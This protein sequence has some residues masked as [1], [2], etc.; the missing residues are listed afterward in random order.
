[1]RRIFLTAAILSVLT[2][3]TARA[4]LSIDVSSE[5]IRV[6]TGFNGSAITIFGVQEQQGA[7]AIVVEGP[8]KTM[9]VKKKSPVFGLWTNTDSRRFVNMP[10]YYEMAASA[11]LDEVAAPET[12]RSNRIGLTNILIAPADDDGTAAFSNALVRIQ[13]DH[14]VYGKTVKPLTYITPALFKA[15]FELPAVVSPGQYKVSA[16]LFHDGALLEQTSASFEVV[17]D[18]W[19]A[20]L[21]HFATNFGLLYG[22]AGVLMAMV[23]GWLA[24]VLLKRE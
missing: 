11:P 12:L 24:T 9:T 3:P 22:F 4:A 15:T 6:T 20:R 21:R 8:S 2:V 1:M 7:L 14:G 16:F 18:G 17:P 13:Q 19:S 5:T 23:A 10:A